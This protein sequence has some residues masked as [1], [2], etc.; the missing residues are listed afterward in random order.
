MVRIRRLFT[1]F[2]C[3]IGS[4][5]SFTEQVGI[6]LYEL[7]TQ[8]NEWQQLQN[9]AITAGTGIQKVLLFLI[10]VIVGFMMVTE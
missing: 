1:Y 8:N 2:I 10:S 7:R 5:L 3:R 9:R 6:N 4:R